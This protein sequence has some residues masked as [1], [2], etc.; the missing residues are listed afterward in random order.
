MQEAER[1]NRKL[2]LQKEKLTTAIVQHGLW[3]TTSQ[4]ETALSIIRSE[5][6]KRE[7]LKVQLRFRKMVLQQQYEDMSVFQ[8]SKKGAGQFPSDV[9][10]QNLLLLIGDAATLPTRN[11][12]S[13]E[14][15]VELVGAQ[16]DHQFTEDDQLVVYSGKVVSQVPGFPDWFNVV[17]DN[18]PDTIYTYRLLEDLNNGD[19]KVV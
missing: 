10:K 5:T 2:L 13:G 6:G 1:K 11:S 18:E 16:I 8:F 4:V 7:A 3:Q 17:Y 9:L 15:T 14:V 12:E 19:L